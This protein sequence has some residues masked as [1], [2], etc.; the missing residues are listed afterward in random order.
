MDR[1]ADPK[2]MYYHNGRSTKEECHVHEKVSVG[3]GSTETVLLMLLLLLHLLHRY[4]EVSLCSSKTRRTV[5][6]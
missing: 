3:L 5:S 2:P 1:S 6:L 4:I